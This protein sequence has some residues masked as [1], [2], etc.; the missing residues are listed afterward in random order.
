MDDEMD[1]H[2]CMVPLVL[3]LARA[4][5]LKEEGSKMPDWAESLLRVLKADDSIVSRY[6]PKGITHRQSYG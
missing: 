5:G 4:C 6:E 2:P 3:M 1:R